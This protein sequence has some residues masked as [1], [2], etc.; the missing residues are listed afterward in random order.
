MKRKIPFILIFL[1]H[2][3][4]SQNDRRSKTVETESSNSGP[5]MSLKVT[6]AFQNF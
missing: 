4:F 1:C 5:K 3:A 6:Q 2:F